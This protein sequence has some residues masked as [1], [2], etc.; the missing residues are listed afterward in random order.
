MNQEHLRIQSTLGDCFFDLFQQSGE[1]GKTLYDE[2]VT[3]IKDTLFEIGNA[4]LD[5]IH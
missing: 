4:D 5:S 2:I 1:D 3:W